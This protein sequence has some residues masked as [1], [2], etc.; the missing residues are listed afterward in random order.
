MFSSAR[1]I[2]ERTADSSPA[3]PPL[4][5]RRRVTYVSTRRFSIFP[6][7]VQTSPSGVQV[8]GVHG[9]GSGCGS[10]VQKRSLNQWMRQW[11]CFSAAA[12]VLPELGTGRAVAGRVMVER[13]RAPEARRVEKCIL[14]VLGGIV[15]GGVWLWCFK[16]WF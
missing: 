3:P 6:S 15:W 9:S 4:I 7:A 8:P 16:I 2:L 10:G 1:P 13:R 11:F 14:F 5:Q 12:T